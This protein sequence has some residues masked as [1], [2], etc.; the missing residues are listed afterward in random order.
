MFYL[1]AQNLWF[2]FYR[3]AAEGVEYVEY[4]DHGLTGNW[5]RLRRT[6]GRGQA[7]E[8]G[9]SPSFSSRAFT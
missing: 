9:K 7:L 1:G 2:Q 8:G 4:S 6:S 5:S 3:F